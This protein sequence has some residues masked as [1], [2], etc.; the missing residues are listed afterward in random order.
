MMSGTKRSPAEVLGKINPKQGIATVEKIAIN[1]VMAGAR[2]EYLPVIISA[3]EALADENFDDL[4]V[5]A[6]AGSFNLLIVVG[7][8]I[9]REIGME[10]GIGFMGH[11]WR[12]NNT[13]GRAVRLSTLNIGRTWPGKND[14]ALT[15]RISAHTFFTFP[16]NADL[17]PWQPYHANRGFKAEDSCVTVASIQGESQTQHFY[18]GMIF[19]WTVD[20]IL[21]NMVEDILKTDRRGYLTWGTKGAGK[22]HG[23]IGPGMN[24]MVI[25]FPELAAELKKIGFDQK[26]LQDEIYKRTSVPYDEL[27]EAERKSLQAG[28]E[29]GI[30]PADRQAVFRAALKPGGKVPALISPENLHFFVAGGA[31]GCAFS[32]SYYR[33]PPYNRTALLTKRITGAALTKA[34]AT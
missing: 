10:A 29:L 32:F 33:I 18:G 27:N 4:H 7:G 14:M 24:H 23:Y 15:G 13:I 26:S 20:S 22:S 31:P 1:A 12:A 6:S 19:T 2:P 25:L 5:L 21:D 8:P 9:T 11:G 34:G 3:V 30:I 16:E 17:S 28:M